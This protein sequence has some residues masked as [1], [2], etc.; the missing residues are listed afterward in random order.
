MI[1]TNSSVRISELLFFA[2][3]GLY[4]IMK[5]IEYTVF[6][7]EQNARLFITVKVVTYFIAV[8]G[9]TYN[10]FSRGISKRGLFLKLLIILFA[11]Y[12]AVHWNEKSVFVVL[13]F[14][15]LFDVKDTNKYL[16]FC[17]KAGIIIYIFTVLCA[18]FNIIPNVVTIT[19]KYGITWRRSSLGFG[20]P[21]QTLMSLMPLI[22]IDTYLHK[23]KKTRLIR[24]C[25]WAVTVMV[26][27]IQSQTI[28]PSIVSFV[29]LILANLSVKEKLLK[30]KHTYIAYIC[31]GV[32][33]MF[34]FMRY[35]EF[36]PVM[37]I[38]RLINYRLSLTITAI[39][40]YGITFFGTGFSNIGTESEYLFLDSDY[41]HM[42]ITNGVIYLIL[43]VYMF[44]LCILWAKRQK[45]S[46]MVL[47]F[48]MIAINSL[49]NNGMFNLVFNPFI[50]ILALALKEKEN[51]LVTM[52]ARYRWKLKSH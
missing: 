12:Q 20:Y 47:I 26:L 28:M 2:S 23:D 27:F 6:A 41:S 17:F 45:D 37:Y 52:G 31:C 9:I 35:C 19:N 25:I 8:I 40:K 51:R 16:R 4:Y 43:C 21:G 36:A 42:L 34:V 18:I 24:S 3:F 48:L 11:L 14:S 50:I 30:G 49:V 33:M 38:D 32:A 46:D 15:F 5:S 44:N 1:R 22:M 13:L 7:N 29:Y 10:I 39:R